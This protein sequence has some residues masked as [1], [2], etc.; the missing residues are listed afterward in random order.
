MVQGRRA[1]MMA[2]RRW[3]VRRSRR[4][5]AVPLYGERRE[6]VWIMKFTH[7]NPK[8][9]LTIDANRLDLFQH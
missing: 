1:L 8:F 5:K 6:V 7:P 3:V 2:K 4:Q 9:V